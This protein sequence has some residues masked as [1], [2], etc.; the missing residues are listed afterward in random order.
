MLTDWPNDAKWGGAT[1]LA[2]IH[3][4]SNPVGSFDIALRLKV[5]CQGQFLFVIEFNQSIYYHTSMFIMEII[6]AHLDARTL[7][8]NIAIAQIIMEKH[9]LDTDH[10][11]KSM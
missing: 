5:K 9:T 10:T 2:K 4:A 3:F 7:L 8:E 6:V 11:R 1:K